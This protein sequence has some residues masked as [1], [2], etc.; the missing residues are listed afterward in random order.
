[1]GIGSA[2]A[3]SCQTQMAQTLKE[4]GHRA[5]PQRLM[6]LSA[7]RHSEGHITAAEV[8]EAVKQSYPFIDVSTVY[9]TLDMLRRMRLVSETHM[10]GDQHAYEWMDA[11]RHHHLICNDCESVTSMEDSFLDALGGQIRRAYGFAADIEHLAIFGLCRDCR[12]DEDAER[13]R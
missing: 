7:V 6:I 3:M 10:G 8:F 13:E 1:M 5:T 2:V 9:R 12:Q 4:Y 11:E